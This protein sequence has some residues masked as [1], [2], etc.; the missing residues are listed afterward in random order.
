MSVTGVIVI[1]A[2]AERDPDGTSKVYTVPSEAVVVNEPP[3]KPMVP[4]TAWAASVVT[5]QSTGPSLPSRVPFPHGGRVV[6]VEVETLVLEVVGIVD[7]VDV[8]VVGSGPS[9]PRPLYRNDPRP[10][11]PANPTV[12]LTLS[13]PCFFDIRPR[14]AR[15]VT[16]CNATARPPHAAE[17]RRCI[18]VRKAARDASSSVNGTTVL[19]CFDDATYEP[20]D[21]TLPKSASQRVSDRNRTGKVRR[22]ETRRHFVYRAML[23]PF[24]SAR[25]MTASAGRIARQHVAMPSSI[26]R[27]FDLPRWRSAPVMA[28][29]P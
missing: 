18:S 2:A 25:P 4:E 5:A 20:E 14:N 7:V 1:F 11:A 3:S 23:L 24:V 29:T 6:V 8:V 21:T 27:S 19:R 15:T 9:R 16:D 13:E 26:P 10:S 22:A 28:G 12:R 17:M